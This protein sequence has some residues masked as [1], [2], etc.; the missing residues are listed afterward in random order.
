MRGW[1]SCSEVPCCASSRNYF[2]RKGRVSDSNNPH[3]LGTKFLFTSQYRQNYFHGC[4]SFQGHTED[5]EPGDKGAEGSKREII[6]RPN[7]VLHSLKQTQH[8]KWRHIGK[9]NERSVFIFDQE[10]FRMRPTESELMVAGAGVGG[11]GIVRQFGIDMYSLLCLKWI[12]NK[13]LL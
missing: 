8:I 7:L 6:N 13:D 11:L 2:P 5:L 9:Q 10:I 12:T 3:V 1:I 4:K